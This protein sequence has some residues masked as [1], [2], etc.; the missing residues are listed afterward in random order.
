[1]WTHTLWATKSIF[2]DYMSPEENVE[3]LLLA[4][5]EPVPKST[6]PCQSFDAKETLRYFKLQPRIADIVVDVF[7]FHDI[8]NSHPLS[9][10]ALSTRYIPQFIP[11]FSDHQPQPPP[12]TS[13]AGLFC[14]HQTSSPFTM[15][16]ELLKLQ[17]SSKPFPT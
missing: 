17:I 16:Q 11:I 8:S 7:H 14:F 5:L 3:F 12:Y 1:M 6:S 2:S 10:T 15:L 9:Q 4:R 13:W